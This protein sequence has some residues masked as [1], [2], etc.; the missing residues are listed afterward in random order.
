MTPSLH[1]GQTKL[2]PAARHA[3]RCAANALELSVSGRL[4]SISLR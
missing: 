2:S 3:L 1:L 4:S